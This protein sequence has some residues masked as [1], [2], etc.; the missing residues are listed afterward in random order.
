MF[1]PKDTLA[2]R[3]ERD[4]AKRKSKV[5][6]SQVERAQRHAA[7][8]KSRAR[9]HYDSQSYA[10]SIGRAIETANRWLPAA[11]RIP[12]WT[13][14]QLRHAAVTEIALENN[15]DLNIARAVA[16]QRSI[17]VTQNYNHADLKIA[18]EQAKKRGGKTREKERLNVK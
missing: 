1:S 13:P 9:E 14:Y 2:E 10:R 5:Q 17:S 4:A 11:E 16:G 6:P 8:P 3:K 12:H 7:N 15:G 18:I